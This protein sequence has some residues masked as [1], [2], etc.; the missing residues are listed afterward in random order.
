MQMKT[1]LKCNPVLEG[2]TSKRHDQIIKPE[3]QLDSENDDKIDDIHI[4]LSK[5]ASLESEV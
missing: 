5:T 3:P 1:L 4:E 2:S